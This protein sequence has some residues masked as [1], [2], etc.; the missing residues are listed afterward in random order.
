M[1]NPQGAIVGQRV[2]DQVQARN[3]K[4]SDGRVFVEQSYVRTWTILSE[5]GT[6]AGIERVSI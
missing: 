4:A 3:I 1:T 2:Q 6:G 5:L